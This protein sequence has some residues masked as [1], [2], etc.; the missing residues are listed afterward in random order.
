ME[1]GL[2]SALPNLAVTTY[3]TH[4]GLVTYPDGRVEVAVAAGIGTAATQFFSLDTQTWRRG[5]NFPVD[6]LEGGSSVQ[7]GDTFFIVGGNDE[8]EAAQRSIY[9]FNVESE[10]WELLPHMLAIPRANQPAAFLVP[11]GFI[12][13]E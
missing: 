1:T 7:Y 10:E 11:K 5:P 2:W 12:G 4:A 3:S 13:C 9:M 8:N 6:I